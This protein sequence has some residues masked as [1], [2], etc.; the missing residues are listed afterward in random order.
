MGKRLGLALLLSGSFGTGLVAIRV[1][2]GH[3]PPLTFTALRLLAVA[4][5]FLTLLIATRRRFRLQASLLRLVALLGVL[6]VAIP[7]T[8]SALA[9]RMISSTLVSILLNM[10]PV[11]SV[12]LAHIFLPDER[13]TPGKLAGVAVAVLGASLVV[14]G[15]SR[16]SGAVAW[17][18]ALWA[19]SLLTVVNALSVASSNVILRR[20]MK[21]GDG[22]VVTGGQMVFGLLLVLPLSLLVEGRPDLGGVTWDGWMAVVWT[23]LVG[24][25]LAYSLSFYMIRRFGVTLA[26]VASTGTP[27][28]TA[29]IGTLFL[30]ET[31]TLLMGIGALCVIVGVLIVNLLARRPQ[32]DRTP[33]YLL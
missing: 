24:C 19:G 11:F 13:L 22:L 2:V 8:I 10:I 25:L 26:A 6:N 12:L 4:V 20:K 30:G 14:W 1:G 18:G 5:A 23:S 29:A 3:F 21:T 32:A 7:Y 28:V 31:L 17:P 33:V 27:L 9:M 16:A 15:S